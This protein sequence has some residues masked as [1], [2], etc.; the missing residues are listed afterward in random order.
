MKKMAKALSKLKNLMTELSKLAEKHE[1]EAA[2]YHSSNL[3]KI[4]ALLGQR[5]QSDIMKKLLKRD[6]SVKESWE[7]IVLYLDREVRLKEQMILVNNANNALRSEGTQSQGND[8]R[9]SSN[10]N[11]NSYQSETRRDPLKCAICDKNGP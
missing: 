8:R 11:V 2:L 7:E 10:S 4:Y 3:A 5:R 1:I 6:V 9:S